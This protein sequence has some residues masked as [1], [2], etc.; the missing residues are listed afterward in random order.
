M[1]N[2]EY[3][4][5]G[6]THAFQQS[7]H[8][9]RRVR[10]VRPASSRSNVVFPAP[11]SP[12]MAWKRPAPKSALTPRN[13][14]KRPNCL[15]T[16]LTVMMGAPDDAVATVFTGRAGQREFAFRRPHQRIYGFRGFFAKGR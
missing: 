14:A 7:D 2:Q 15:T 11:L 13:A 1:R 3:R 12:R 8:L 5:A 4:L 6:V 10:C 9:S 16:L